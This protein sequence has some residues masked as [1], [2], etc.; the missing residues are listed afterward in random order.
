PTLIALACLASHNLNYSNRPVR[1][2]MPGGVAG[3]QLYLAAP[4]ADFPCRFA[5]FVTHKQRLL[6]ILLANL[7]SLPVL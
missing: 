5:Q 2:R 3:E 4:Y 7:Q 1:T 6:V